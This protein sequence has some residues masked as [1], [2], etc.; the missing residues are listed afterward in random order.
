MN[1]TASNGDTVMRKIFDFDTVQ[2]GEILGRKEILISDALIRTCANAIGSTHPWYLEDSP[3]GGRIAPPTIFDNESLNM[4]DEQYER[5][6]SI[7]ARQAWDFEYPARLGKKVTLTVTIEDKFVKRQRPYIVMSL[8][9][10]DDD[11]ITLCR[12][13]HTSLMTLIR[14]K[15][16]NCGSRQ[17]DEQNV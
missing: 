14:E 1:I 7:H 10:V 2:V 6:G 12:S 16:T 3:F 15:T 5:F 13:K 9:A 17:T 4:L 8:T 11:G